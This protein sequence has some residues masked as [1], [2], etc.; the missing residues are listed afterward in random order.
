MSHKFQVGAYLEGIF[1]GNTVEMSPP[2]VD[3]NRGRGFCCGD[4][5]DEAVEGCHPQRLQ[6]DKVSN[7]ESRDP[8]PTHNDHAVIEDLGQARLPYQETGMLKI[9]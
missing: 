8:S 7:E 1:P 2:S 9:I 3:R 6:V 5:D 4:L